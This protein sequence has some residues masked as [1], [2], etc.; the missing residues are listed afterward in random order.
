[1]VVSSSKFEYSA[2]KLKTTSENK[3]YVGKVGGIEQIWISDV[4][5]ARGELQNVLANILSGKW[6]FYF[7]IF[8]VV[9][10][11]ILSNRIYV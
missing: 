9:Y 3:F 5:R 10:F 6:N 2:N 7:Y 11:Y 8:S 4:D 1:M